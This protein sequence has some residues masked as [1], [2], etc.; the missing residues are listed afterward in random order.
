[1]LLW[2]STSASDVAS[3]LLLLTGVTILVEDLCQK[4]SIYQ[5]YRNLLFCGSW[6]SVFIDSCMEH[7]CHSHK[8]TSQVI[9][10]CISRNVCNNWPF[11]DSCRTDRIHA[12]WTQNDV[13]DNRSF[14][15]TSF[16]HHICPPL[17]TP[18]LQ[19]SRNGQFLKVACLV[20]IFFLKDVTKNM[21][22]HSTTLEYWR[23]ILLEAAQYTKW[24]KKCLITRNKG[25]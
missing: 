7:N 25:R 19:L 16:W 9:W 8:Y 23:N 6:E 4:P 11:R 14:N 20:Q 12:Q 21:I 3:I 13:K 18:L 15:M 24:L 5:S 10:L 1:M 17:Q 2:R 22:Y